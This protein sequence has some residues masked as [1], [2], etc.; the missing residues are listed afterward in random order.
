MSGEINGLAAQEY[1]ANL[2]SKGDHLSYNDVANSNPF[3]KELAKEVAYNNLVKENP[4]LEDFSVEMFSPMAGTV[5]SKIIPTFG[6]DVGQGLA[7]LAVPTDMSRRMFIKATP[8]AMMAIPAA[9]SGLE[10]A[11]KALAKQGAI[12]VAKKASEPILEGVALANNVARSHRIGLSPEFDKVLLAKKEYTQQTYGIPTVELSKYKKL[13]NEDVLSG[14][15][16]REVADNKIAK[17]Q[18][19][20]TDKDIKKKIQNDSKLN[21]MNENIE[22]LRRGFVNSG[23]KT[24]NALEDFTEFVN[25]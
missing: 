6:K 19:V 23:V 21:S 25:K 8:S 1:L 4:P 5:A 10:S 12:K 24:N 7:A 3:L 16:S 9:I 15:V 18:S 2:V 14:K 11:G 20:V 17:V 13:L 22:E